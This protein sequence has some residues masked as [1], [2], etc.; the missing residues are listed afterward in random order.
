MGVGVVHCE[1]DVTVWFGLVA[2]VNL[3]HLTIQV[4]QLLGLDIG[5][6]GVGVELPPYVVA[7]DTI[8]RCLRA[9]SC[10]H[11]LADRWEKPELGS[12]V[13]TSLSD[14]RP[15]NSSSI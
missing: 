14:N 12:R 13:S 10:V 4:Y 2:R 6:G 8:R 9:G 3:G 5:L 1:E 11:V 15:H 7:D